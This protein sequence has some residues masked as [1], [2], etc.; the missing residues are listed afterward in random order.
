MGDGWILD[1]GAKDILSSVLS[2]AAFLIS[3]GSAYYTVFRER[4]ELSF[5]ISDAMPHMSIGKS[6]IDLLLSPFLTFV[7]SGTVPVSINSIKF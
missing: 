3:A 7:N 5:L 2:V 1:V 6:K 4:E